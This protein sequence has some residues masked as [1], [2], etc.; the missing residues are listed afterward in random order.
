[1]KVKKLARFLKFNSKWMG[2]SFHPRILGAQ[3]KHAC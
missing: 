2:T 3:K 1:M